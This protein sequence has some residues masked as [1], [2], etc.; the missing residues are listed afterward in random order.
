MIR[1]L[2]SAL[3]A[4]SLTFV[5]ISCNQ[6]PTSVGSNLIAQK[7]KFTFQQFDSQQSDVHQNTS[8]YPFTPKLG[9]SEYVVVGKTPDIESSIMYRYQIVLPDTTLAAVNSGSVKVKDA[10]VQ[11]RT[12]YT[13]GDK[14]AP[15]DFTVH[16]I[17]SAWTAPGFDRDSMA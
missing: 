4:V 9:T 6:D 5:L 14:S 11:T 13:I 7:D 1:F 16:Q 8:Y 12:R 2:R 3:I 15:F 10:W 17:R